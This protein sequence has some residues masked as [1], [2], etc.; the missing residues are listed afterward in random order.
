MPLCTTALYCVVCTTFMYVCDVPVFATGDQV[1]PLSVEDSHLIT[2]PVCP[3]SEIVPLLPLP[4]QKV[5]APVVVPPT[6]GALSVII[7]KLEFGVHG[8]AGVIV[9]VNL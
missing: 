4:A 7:T 3:L 1:T 9:Q 6:E 2:P 5:L 8:S